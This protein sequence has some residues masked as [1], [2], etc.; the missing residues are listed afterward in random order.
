MEGLAY[1]FLDI[2]EM[3]PDDIVDQHR[4]AQ[5]LNWLDRRAGIQFGPLMDRLLAAL[6]PDDVLRL[7]HGVERASSPFAC[8]RRRLNVFLEDFA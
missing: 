3:P 8:L 6:Y 7:L 2:E 1:A 5:R 4:V